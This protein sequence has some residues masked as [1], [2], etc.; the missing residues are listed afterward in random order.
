MSF[1]NTEPSS[2]T[3][4]SPVV[5]DT[6]DLTI[7]TYGNGV[8]Y[9]LKAQK[10]LSE[11]HALPVKVI[12]LRWMA[13]MD[14]GGL[15]NEISDCLNILIVD[16][17]RKTGSWSEGLVAMMVEQLASVPRI[18]VVAADDC[19]IPLGKA[20]TAGLPSVEDIIAGALELAGQG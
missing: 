11:I 12:D 2:S 17:C 1:S 8:Y 10:E 9:S 14:I 15:V 18:K 20:A 7:L 13:P 5:I 19:F 6:N 3:S 4:R 16:E